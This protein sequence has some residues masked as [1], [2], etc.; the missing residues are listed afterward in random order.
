MK[1]KNLKH[2][3]ML[4]LIVLALTVNA[5]TADNNQDGTGL[6][7]SEPYTGSTYSD[8]W[9]IVT[10]DPY[11]VL[12]QN[13][14]TFKSFFS[15]GKNKLL[16]AA[17]RTIGNRADILPYFNKLLHPN[18][19][20][21]SGTWNIVEETPYTGY[22]SNGSTGI[23]IARASTALSETKQGEYRG[24]GLAGKI[25]PTTDLDKK[26]VPAN[27]F[28]ADDLG[29]TK[30]EHYT[31]AAFT[32][33][34]KLSL[35]PEHVW[36]SNVLANI[37]FSLGKADSSPGIRQL[38]QI[39]ELGMEFP[40]NA[41]TPKWMKLQ[42]SSGQVKVDEVDFRDELNLINYSDQKL[43]FDIYVTTPE[44]TKSNQ[45]WIYIGYIE[46]NDYVASSSTDHRLHFNHP[47]IKEIRTK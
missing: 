9:N 28:T 15:W 34:P 39:S 26:S 20:A 44:S 23:I 27:F 46:F 38:Y 25:Y 47:K 8:V 31:D 16:Q 18:G 33:E 11:V 30:T 24:F 2:T 7:F 21:L 1:T 32:N 41:L 13:K 19:V 37:A 40:E 10:S 3:F 35:H 5:Y 22:F 29:G 43:F 4:T 45:E 42:A 6:D 36:I 17:N 12:P 14:V